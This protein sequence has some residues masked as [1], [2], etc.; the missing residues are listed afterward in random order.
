M[1]WALKCDICGCYVDTNSNP[2]ERIIPTNNAVRIE[3]GDYK[4]TYEICES[5]GRKIVDLIES[6]KKEK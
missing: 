5:C 2:F 4:H 1:S 6:L 3:C